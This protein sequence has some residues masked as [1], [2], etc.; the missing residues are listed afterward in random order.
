MES[1]TVQQPKT[2]QKRHKQGHVTSDKMDQTVVVS[3]VRQVAH[4]KY[5]KR[6]LTTNK[7]MAHNP[8]NTYKMGDEVIIEECRPRSRHKRWIVIGYATKPVATE[9]E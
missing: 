6:Y 1:S 4:P 2:A 9:Q 3:V 5:H 7:F 8:N